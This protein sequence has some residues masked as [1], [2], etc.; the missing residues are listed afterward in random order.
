MTIQEATVKTIDA[1]KHLPILDEDDP[2]AKAITAET[3]ATFIAEAGDTVRLHDL[4]HR[5]EYRP[6]ALIRHFGNAGP[7]LC[8][9]FERLNNTK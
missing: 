4:L 2:R 9:Y 8:V 6:I 5:G 1:L 7:C 3:V